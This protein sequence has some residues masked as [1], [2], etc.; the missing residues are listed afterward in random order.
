MEFIDVVASLDEDYVGTIEIQRPPNNFFDTALIGT[1]AD[2]CDALAARGCR[3][4]VLCAAGHHFC[5]GANFASKAEPVGAHLY[6]VAVRLFE[7]P[8]PMVAAVQGSAVGGGLGLARWRP[9]FEW[10]RR[11]HASPRTSRVSA[12]TTVSGFPS[13][14]Q[15]WSVSR[16]RTS[17]SLLGVESTEPKHIA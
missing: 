16:L 17:C 2:A 5:A 10:R 12:F 7:Q 4:V 1:L 3:A 11:S 14:C 8:L 9:T 13:L 15:E 6:D